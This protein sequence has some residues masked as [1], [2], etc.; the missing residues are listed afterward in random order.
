MS[1]LYAELNRW[2]RITYQWGEHDCV[3]LCADWVLRM[4]G[5]D[6]AADVRLTYDSAA[7][8]QRVTR[9]FTDPVG[10][11]GP[12]LDR[13]GLPR[14][15]DPRPGDVGVIL[16]LSDRGVA[17]PHMALCLGRAWALKEQSGAVIAVQP[18]KILQAWGVGYEA[19]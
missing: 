10:A 2:Q 16:L 17:R 7:E 11:V 13:A 6:P 18:I 4:R 9:F 8:C 19:A 15:D 14:T 5:V 1:P 3:T 12:Y